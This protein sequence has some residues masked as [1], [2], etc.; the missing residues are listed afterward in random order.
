MDIANELAEY[1]DFFGVHIANPGI[2]KIHCPIL[3]FYGTHD[4]IG[5]ENTLELLKT[6]IKK[7]PKGPRSVT[8]T[9]IK[10]TDHMYMGEEMQVAD[11]ITKWI[12]DILKSK[13]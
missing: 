3:A 4:D 1:K 10:N 2:T 11:V 5:N 12:D 7:Q 13:N 8:T 9:M 6:S